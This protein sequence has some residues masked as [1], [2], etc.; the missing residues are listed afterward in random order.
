MVT[1]DSHADWLEGTAKGEQGAFP[2]SLAVPR[3]AEPMEMTVR[4][5]FTI[6]DSNALDCDG[7]QRPLCQREEGGRAGAKGRRCW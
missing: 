3:L 2:R 5:A 6:G 7:K 1:D 4:R